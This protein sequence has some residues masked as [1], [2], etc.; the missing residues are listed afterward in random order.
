MESSGKWALGEALVGWGYGGT[1]PF[2]QALDWDE[3]ALGCSG[4]GGPSSP[5]AIDIV[6]PHQG[7]PALDVAK[8]NS[9]L[10]KGRAVA[11]GPER[12]VL[13]GERVKGEDEALV[14]V[15]GKVGLAG[16]LGSRF[17]L[18]LALCFAGGA[19][20][21]TLSAALLGETTE[22]AGEVEVAAMDAAST[23]AVAQDALGSLNVL[24][25]VATVGTNEGIARDELLE[26]V[27]GVHLLEEQLSGAVVGAGLL[28]SLVDDVAYG[29]GVPVD[30][31]RV[32]L[33]AGGSPDAQEGDEQERHGGLGE[34]GATQ[35]RQC[36]C[37]ASGEVEQGSEQTLHGAE[38]AFKGSL[39]RRGTFLLGLVVDLELLAGVAGRLSEVGGTLVDEELDAGQ[40]R[41]GSGDDLDDEAGVLRGLCL[42]GREQ[43]LDAPARVLGGYEAQVDPEGGDGCGV[44]E[45]LEVRRTELEGEAALVPR[46]GRRLGRRRRGQRRRRPI[47]T[48]APGAKGALG[49]AEGRAEAAEG[50]AVLAAQLFGGGDNALLQGGIADAAGG[51]DGSSEVELGLGAGELGS[52]GGELGLVRLDRGAATTPMGFVDQ[53]LEIGEQLRLEARECLRGGVI[54]LA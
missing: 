35:R 29:L 30:D 1:F 13:H 44:G 28:A 46:P 23:G 47:P 16:A 39:F 52:H 45:G 4:G 8:R 42:E 15:S 54:V 49:D 41:E 38:C 51:D 19:I 7:R 37:E 22:D 36:I 48:R 24:E 25:G 43:L 6:V 50:E 3:G 5:E 40:I 27:V 53:T 12:L 10:S 32:A 14:R 17:T 9:E 33:C 31:R 2:E 18:A 34:V 20:G 11:V 21:G 26:V